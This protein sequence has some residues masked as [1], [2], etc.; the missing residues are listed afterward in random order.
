MAIV[1]EEEMRGTKRD[2]N[3]VIVTNRE[4]VE[5]GITNQPTDCPS[6]DLPSSSVLVSTPSPTIQFPLFRNV[7]TFLAVAGPTQP[8][9]YPVWIDTFRRI[10][11]QPRTWSFE[12]SEQAHNDRWQ[13]VSNHV[14]VQ[15]PNQSPQ[16]IN[17]QPTD[18]RLYLQRWARFAFTS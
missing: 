2:H 3:E 11:L 15:L 10:M 4:V 16:S 8:T 5:A 12:K 17:R 14:T 9:S 13:I 6:R 18:N 7:S 1:W